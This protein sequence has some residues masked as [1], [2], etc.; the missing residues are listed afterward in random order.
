MKDMTTRME[1]IATILRTLLS[2]VTTM[3]M[4]MT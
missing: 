4:T 1:S 2:R 3:Y